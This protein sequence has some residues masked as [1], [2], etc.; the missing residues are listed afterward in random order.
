MKNVLAHCGLSIILFTMLSSFSCD[1]S[2][3]D[4]SG[5]AVSG[6]EGPGITVI[7][8]NVQ[9]FF[10]AVDTGNEYED[11]T[12][13]K[14]AWTEAKYTARLD[15]LCSFI[16]S[17][18]ADV[19]CFM[20]IENQSVIHDIANRLHL[21]HSRTAAYPYA[22]FCRGNTGSIGCAVLSRIP[23]ENMTAHNAT[24]KGTLPVPLYNGYEAG[25]PLEP[26]VMRPLLE[27]TLA[28]FEE[29]KP[30]VKLFV[31]H[32]KSKSSGGRESELWRTT[33]EC[34]L[35]MHMSGALNRGYPCIAVGDYNRDLNEFYWDT[36]TSR[37]HKRVL[38]R[39]LFGSL[40]VESPWFTSNQA[41]SYYYDEDWS[42]IDHIFT[43]G[44]LRCASF[45]VL[46]RGELVNGSGTPNSYSV[47]TGEGNSDHFPLKVKIQYTND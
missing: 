1:M 8:W 33:Q 22:A 44:G 37:Q 18:N 2:F 17:T 41:G 21:R 4:E 5:F 35:S 23:L 46:N 7:S 19:Y 32:W 26:P 42:R 38:L 45:D 14:S 43:A 30:P 12:G 40:A 24:F 39:N 36:E 34:V 27:V 20:E 29:G 6:P 13:I 31:N 10:D 28:P 47:W 9:E 3:R 11:F 25:I 16:E 15:R